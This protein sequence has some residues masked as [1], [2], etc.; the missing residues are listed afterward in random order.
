MLLLQNGNIIRLYYGGYS[1]SVS[2]SSV[3]DIFHGDYIYVELFIYSTIII[4]IIVNTVVCY[5]LWY[6][7]LF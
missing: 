5:D 2:K 6:Y 4:I 3:V 1:N 7:S